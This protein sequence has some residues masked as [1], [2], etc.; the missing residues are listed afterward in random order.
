MRKKTDSELLFEGFVKEVAGQPGLK[1]VK[2][3]CNEGATDEI[4]E[5]A[6]G[7]KL[8][9]IRSLL[10]QLNYHGI[11]EYTREK[12]MQSGWFTYTWKVNKSR[13]LQN[14]LAK[15]K[16]EYA[17]MR[18]QLNCQGDNTASYDCPKGCASYFFDKAM[19]N[20]FACIKCKSKLKFAEGDSAMQELEHHITAIESLI[21]SPNLI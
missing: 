11:V 18:L 3:I 15:K 19:D 14:I 20:S 12:N 6:S 2:N 8:S 16:N 5:K 9:A 13:A 21:N 10:N 7:L 4:I 17:Q 1:V